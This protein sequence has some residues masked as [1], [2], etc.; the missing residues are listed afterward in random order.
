MS[1]NFR[2][3]FEAEESELIKSDMIKLIDIYIID[4]FAKKSG[5]A[6]ESRCRKKGSV[7]C[8]CYSGI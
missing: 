3:L 6:K 7:N 5:K 1:M 2:K 8:N 4:V